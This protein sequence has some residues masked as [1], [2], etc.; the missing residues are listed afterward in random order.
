M[1]ATQRDPSDNL[2]LSKDAEDKNP[3][4]SDG[5]PQAHTETH[6]HT[7]IHTGFDIK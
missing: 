7:F 1:S 2:M 3:F 6:T 5:Y 4:D